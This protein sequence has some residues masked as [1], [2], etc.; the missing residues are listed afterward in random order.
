MTEDLHWKSFENM[1][2]EFNDYLQQFIEQATSGT[3]KEMI[4]YHLGWRDASLQYVNSNLGKRS[5][6]IL[7]LLSYLL[8]SSSYQ[9]AFPVAGALEILHNFSLIFDDIQDRDPLR[10]GRPSVWSIWGEDEA[11][12]AGCA[13]QAL[14]HR[15]ISQMKKDFGADSVLEIGDYL[16]ASMMRLSEGQQLD[17]KMAKSQNDVNMEQY[18]DMIQ[19]KTATLFEAATYLG[20]VSAGADYK[21]ANLCK[22]F[23][24]NLGIAFQ[25]FDD[26]IGIWGLKEKGLDKSCSD[27]ENRKKTYPIIFTYSHCDH[28][29]EINVMKLYYSLQPLTQTNRSDLHRLFQQ[30]KALAATFEAGQSYLNQSIELLRHV[31]G[32]PTIKQAIEAWVL[33]VVNRQIMSIDKTVSASQSVIV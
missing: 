21:N 7:C 19:K 18:L 5:R 8:F 13:M 30:K 27:L 9:K 31:D 22:E 15:S 14:V 17:I 28:P 20:A 6:P 23:G 26:A 29:L 10:R 25:L 4:E 24:K 12:N 16:S 11:I 32:D 33:Y 2:N 3:L 1:M